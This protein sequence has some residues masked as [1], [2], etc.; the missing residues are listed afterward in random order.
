MV[1]LAS[2][3]PGFLGIESTRDGVGITVSY[4]RDMESIRQWSRHA[5]HVKAKQ[6]GKDIWYEQFR[7]RIAKVEKDY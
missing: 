7:T 1:E 4:W 6:K 5:E 2:Q 3:Q